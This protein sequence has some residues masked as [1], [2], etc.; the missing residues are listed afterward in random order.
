MCHFSG[1]L[2]Q[3]KTEIKKNGSS[4]FDSESDFV[5]DVNSRMGK[6]ASGI[7]DFNGSSDYVELY[8]VGNITGGSVTVKSDGGLKTRF[9]AYKL[10]GV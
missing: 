3:F 4:H 2:N 8:A 5:S 6:E 10:I 7:I 1:K 9:G